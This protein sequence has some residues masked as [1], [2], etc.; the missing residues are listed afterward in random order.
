VSTILF[1]KEYHKTNFLFDN[2][3]PG[4]VWISQPHISQIW[5][6]LNMGSTIYQLS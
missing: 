6:L 5:S 1:Q 3:A 2:H 4:A